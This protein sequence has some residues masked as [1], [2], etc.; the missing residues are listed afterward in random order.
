MPADIAKRTEPLHA[1]HS[2]GDDGRNGACDNGGA[3]SGLATSATL[4]SISV[5]ALVRRLK[6][7]GEELELREEVRTA[8]VN[9]L[10]STM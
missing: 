4:D 8:V 3:A 2:H 7:L 5:S 10:V 6:I 1:I 9:V